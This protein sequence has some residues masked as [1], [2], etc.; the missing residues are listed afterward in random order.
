[1]CSRLFRERRLKF[2]NLF[3]LA[4]AVLEQ[5][6]NKA[7]V[8]WLHQMDR[9]LFTHVPVSRPDARMGC[10]H[11]FAQLKSLNVR[12]L[13]RPLLVGL[14]VIVAGLS[15]AHAAW[16]SPNPY[17]LASVTLRVGHRLPAAPHRQ[18]PTAQD[19]PIYLRSLRRR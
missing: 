1:M 16:V 3:A 2:F 17:D 7:I 8:P 10:R 15:K 18:R 11:P 4:G 9:W 14:I 13:A 6:R 5:V 12:R 19:C